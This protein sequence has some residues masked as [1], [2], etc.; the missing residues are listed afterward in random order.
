MQPNVRKMLDTI[1]EMLAGDANEARDLWSVLTALRG[2]DNED[3]ELKWRTTAVIRAKAFP[4]AAQTCVHGMAV[5]VTGA[6]SVRY[7]TSDLSHF[8]SHVYSAARALDIPIT[9]PTP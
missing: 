3:T 6:N 1:D 9:E 2:P 5:V 4:K 8:G 7:C